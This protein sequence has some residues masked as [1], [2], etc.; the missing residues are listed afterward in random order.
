MNMN[1]YKMCKIQ[2]DP[3]FY[4]FGFK[5]TTSLLDNYSISG[6][7]SPLN[8]L[9]RDWQANRLAG[10]WKP[11]AVIGDVQAMNDYPMVGSAPAFSERAVVALRDL[12][13]PNGEILPLETPTG[14]GTYFVYNTLT[15]ADVLDESRSDISWFGCNE[16][17]LARQIFHHEFVAEKLGG[18]SIFRIPIS[19]YFIY[20]TET[21][22]ARAREHGLQ[23]FDFRKVWPLPPGT[24]WEKL[25]R[26][27]LE[28]MPGR[29]KPVKP[30]KT[31]A[32][33]QPAR[34]VTSR[35]F[36]PGEELDSVNK[37]LQDYPKELGWDIPAMGANDI[38][39]KIYETLCAIYSSEMK[40]EEKLDQAFWLAFA[41]GE[42]L[43]KELQW[44]WAMLEDDADHKT[45]VVAS[46]NRSHAVPVL[47][48]IGKLATTQDDQTSLLLYNMIVAN[49]LT[50]AQP[51]ELLLMS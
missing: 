2:D 3:R 35:P 20:V 6:D 46:P 51:G 40:E 39:A 7:F 24:D 49:D 8:D 28:K 1:I 22:V 37:A 47:Q 38:Q 33:A 4:G 26:D 42:T 32:E 29:P 41:W 36:K 21:F 9:S 5:D 17:N 10:I 11:R 48:F 14:V 13:Q 31:P 16:K 18:L 43:V 23:G 15:I 30:E 12:L 45:P 50:A 34:R 27:E 25:A 44:E 19:R